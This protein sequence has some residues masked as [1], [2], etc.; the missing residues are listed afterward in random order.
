MGY[1]PTI[2]YGFQKPEKT[3]AFNVDDLNNGLD[4][5]DEVIKNES[6]SDL[7][8]EID[9]SNNITVTIIKGDGSVFSDTKKINDI[10]SAGMGLLIFP[11]SFINTSNV[12][13]IDSFETTVI[14]NQP[15]TG[16]IPLTNGQYKV[17]VTQFGSSQ[18]VEVLVI[19]NT[20]I[21]LDTVTFTLGVTDK[22]ST[23]TINGTPVPIDDVQILK[24]DATVNFVLTL[25]ELVGTGQYF[26]ASQTL[27]CNADGTIKP[28]ATSTITIQNNIT[29]TP[30]VSAEY[31]VWICG[32]GGGGKGGSTPFYQSGNN[33]YFLGSAGNAG[34]GGYVVA[35]KLNIDANTSIPIT[36]GSGGSGGSGGVYTS[37]TILNDGKNGSPGGTTT[38]G[39]YM[40]AVGGEG[41]GLSPSYPSGG[42]GSN[43]TNMDIFGVSIAY[44]AGG[45]PAWNDYGIIIPGKS[46]GLNSTYLFPNAGDGGDSAKQG[47]YGSSWGLATADV[48]G[49]GGNG[50]SNTLGA[51]GRGGNG[52]TAQGTNGYAGG[53]GQ[54]GAVAIRR[55]IA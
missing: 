10:D 17:T 35:K 43:S 48:G 49:T 52:A 37:N 8:I 45:E 16:N 24:S 12:T 33:R 42:D 15:I 26:T 27:S 29:I 7:N 20:Q 34:H 53:N 55:L 4:K 44:G 47:R 50:L 22:I 32:G 46:S 30:S 2:N 21:S 31:E 19:G 40:S 18:T 25:E 23:M 1:V 54:K 28:T 6:I 3:N 13:I 9:E 36:I 38:F 11:S 5:A 14:D 51:G 41:G 39:T